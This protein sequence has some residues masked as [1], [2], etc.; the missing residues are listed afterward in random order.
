MVD[1]GVDGDSTCERR[2]DRWMDAY[3]ERTLSV[4]E[5]KKSYLTI[6]IIFFI[7]TLQ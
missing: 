1:I 3:R 6:G 4:P 2:L 5:D 7:V